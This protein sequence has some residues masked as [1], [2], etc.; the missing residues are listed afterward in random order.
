MSRSKSLQVYLR[1]FLEERNMH[2]FSETYDTES[3]FAD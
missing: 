1:G 2:F 3:R